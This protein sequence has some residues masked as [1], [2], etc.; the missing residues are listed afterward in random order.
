MKTNTIHNYR[1]GI[2]RRMFS[3]AYHIPERRQIDD[4][5][6]VSPSVEHVLPTWEDNHL[7]E[8]YHRACSAE[9]RVKSLPAAA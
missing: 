9:H 2:E 7:I 4:R 8:G 6:K 5:R 3:Y 1:A